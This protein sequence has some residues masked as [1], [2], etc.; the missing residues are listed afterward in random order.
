MNKAMR[1]FV[2][3]AVATALLA[4][5][6]SCFGG[7][8]SSGGRSGGGGVPFKVRMAV[9]DHLSIDASQGGEILSLSGKKTDSYV[10]GSELWEVDVEYLPCSSCSKQRLSGISVHVP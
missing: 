9:T 6:S 5:A 3:V 2:L 10:D 1:N 7:G 8:S 4:L